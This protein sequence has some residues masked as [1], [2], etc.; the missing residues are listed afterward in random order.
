MGKWIFVI[1]G[2]VAWWSEW[3]TGSQELGDLRRPSSA[4]LEA[5]GKQLGSPEANLTYFESPI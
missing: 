4:L 1:R 3:R 2:G 5:S